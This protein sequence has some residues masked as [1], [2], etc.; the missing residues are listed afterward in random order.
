MRGAAGRCP[1]SHSKLPAAFGHLPHSPLALPPAS[2]RLLAA[3]HRWHS[4]QL[5]PACLLC[6][7]WKRHHSSVW[8][9]QSSPSVI[10]LLWHLQGEAGAVWVF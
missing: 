1:Q 10:A 8:A 9:G 5:A 7:F 4:P 3:S 6:P 2:F